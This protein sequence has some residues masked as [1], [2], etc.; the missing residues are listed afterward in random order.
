MEIFYF[1]FFFLA[2]EIA[3]SVTQFL[4]YCNTEEDLFLWLCIKWYHVI[5]LLVYIP[6]CTR[7]ANTCYNTGWALLLSHC[8]QTGIQCMSRFSLFSTNSLCRHPT[9]QNLQYIGN[10]VHSMSSRPRR[11]DK[12]DDYGRQMI[13]GDKEKDRKQKWSLLILL[14]M[15][16][17]VSQLLVGHFS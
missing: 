8:L 12:A 10:K 13:P 2:K 17:N 9:D 14:T 6:N 15:F 11:P 7:L 1:F 3:E 16:W 5:C 4:L